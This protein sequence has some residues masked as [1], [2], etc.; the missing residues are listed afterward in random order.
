MF[1]NDLTQATLV[2][3]SITD[4]VL[5]ESNLSDADLTNATLT[6]VTI[7]N[8]NL[9]GASLVG[10]TITEVDIAAAAPKLEHPD[11]I[12]GLRTI[13]KAFNW[14]T[15]EVRSVAFLL[16]EHG[17]LTHDEAAWLSGY[18]GQNAPMNPISPT[19]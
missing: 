19:G 13:A 6:D 7:A 1:G 18:D 2:G 8:C 11:L 4:S 16:F 3:S 17:H 12:A 10:A 15:L 9:A 14:D 5:S